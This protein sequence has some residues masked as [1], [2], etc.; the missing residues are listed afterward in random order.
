MGEVL[1]SSDP[2]D[3]RTPPIFEEPLPYPRRSPTPL[4][5]FCP[6]F[7][8]ICGA[9]NRRWRGSSIFEAEHRR[10]KMR[11]SSIVGSE[12]RR[13]GVLR[14]S[15]PEDRRILP[16]S[17]LRSRKIEEPPHLRSTIFDPED[18]RTPHLRSST[19]KIEEPAPSSIFGRR[20]G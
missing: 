1:R 2:K 17:D 8:P 9:E 18:R 5:V 4:S 11:K 10:L 6:L 20:S 14:S 15:E 7:Y 12:D 19:S 3:R 13:W 16:I